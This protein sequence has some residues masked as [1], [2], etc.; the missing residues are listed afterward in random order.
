MIRWIASVWSDLLFGARLCRRAPGPTLASITVMAAGVALVVTMASI[1]QGVLWRGLPFPES[2]RIVSLGHDNQ[3]WQLSFED[4]DVLRKD[5]QEVLE[6]VGGHISLFNVV[7]ADGKNTEG[8][9]GSYVTPDLFASLGVPPALGRLFDESDGDPAAPATAMVS[10]GLWQRLYDGSPDVVG[11]SLIFNREPMTVIGVMP[12][13]FRF[14]YR[15]EVWAALRPDVHELKIAGVM[16]VGKLAPGVTPGE[17]RFH[18]AP[19]LAR[20]GTKRTSE[21]LV[22]PYTEGLTTPEFKRALDLM[23]LAVLAVLL[24]SCLNLAS[25]RLAAVWRRE[26]ELGLR[27]ALGASRWRLIRQLLAE[28][29]LLG[30]GGALLGTFAALLLVPSI[31]RLLRSSSFLYGFWIDIRVDGLALAVAIGAAW[32]A[33]LLGGLLPALFASRMPARRMTADASSR[34][35]GGVGPGLRTLVVAEIALCCALLMGAGLAVRTAAALADFESGMDPHSLVRGRVS[36]YQARYEEAEQ[37]DGFWSSVLEGLASRPG[38]ES[39]G[40]QGWSSSTGAQPVRVEASGLQG[41]DEESLPLG[42]VRLVSSRTLET[43]GIELVFGDGFPERVRRSEETPVILSRHLAS[44]AFPTAAEAPGRLVSLRRD[45]KELIEARVVGVAADTFDPDRVEGAS[46]AE[47]SLYLPLERDPPHS[48]HL[49]VRSEE[50]LTAVAEAIRGG[51]ARVE[52]LAAVYEIDLMTRIEARSRWVERHLRSL[53][54]LFAFVALLLTGFGL[55]A[56]LS[57]QIGS[58]LREFGIRVALGADS[59]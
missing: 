38:V 39:V 58:R 48:A 23:S 14:P 54:S 16:G 29:V 12:P 40:L 11:S 17:A 2:D 35:L 4:L 13:G 19:L 10:H 55:N 22:L 26:G 51:I 1:L 30:T 21:F 6:S 49:F 47:S 5:G 15:H 56:V 28:S 45:G 20:Q 9:I 52:P 34:L 36:L 41:V 8:L 44:K 27:K 18:L 31:D 37:R 59:R 25:L 7:T 32:S 50:P 43:L 42:E 57:F 46:F 24:I 33:A 3:M 53:F